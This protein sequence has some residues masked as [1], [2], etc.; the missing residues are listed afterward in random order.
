MLILNSL[1]VFSRRTALSYVRRD[2]LRFIHT[3]HPILNSKQRIK[4]SDLAWHC[5]EKDW[6]VSLLTQLV[7]TGIY[8]TKLFVVNKDD[9]GEEL[10]FDVVETFIDSEWNKAVEQS[11][12]DISEQECACNELVQLNI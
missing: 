9:N 11:G 8:D 2:F 12:D 10:E 7:R 5:M 6:C 3:A 4:I 1:R